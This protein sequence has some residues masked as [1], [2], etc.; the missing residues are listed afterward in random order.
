MKT[1]HV[2]KIPLKY[3]IVLLLLVIALVGS[4]ALLPSQKSLS[5]DKQEPKPSQTVEKIITV[6]GTAACL[7][8]KDTTRPQTMECA[9]GFK[10]DDGTYYA[11]RDNSSDYSGINSA[12]TNK[13]L[14][15][16]GVFKETPSAIYQDKGVIT[17]QSYQLLE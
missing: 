9:L 3:L 14:R 7:P 13:R 4:L 1:A 16:T 5:E 6:E 12:G 17:V 15:V 8:H 10:A 11:L 2:S